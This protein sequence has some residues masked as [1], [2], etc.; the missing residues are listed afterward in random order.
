LERKI[1]IWR[2]NGFILRLWFYDRRIGHPI[3]GIVNSFNE[4]NP[5]HIHLHDLAEAVKVGIWQLVHTHGI[6]T[7]GICDGIATAEI[8]QSTFLPS[9]DI[10]LLVSNVSSSTRFDELSVFVHAIKSYQGCFSER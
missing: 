2:I 1:Q 5:G 10:M 4:V 6:N 3:I 9:R 8:N 7:I